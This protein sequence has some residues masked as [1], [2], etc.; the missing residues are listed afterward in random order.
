MQDVVNALP[1]SLRGSQ[2]TSLDLSTLV[3]DV[4]ITVLS[5]LSS[6]GCR[7]AAAKAALLLRSA[8]ATLLALVLNLLVI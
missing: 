3:L 6:V 7:R 5:A 1:D 8:L 4:I 2:T